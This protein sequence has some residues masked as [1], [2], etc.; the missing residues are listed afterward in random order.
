MVL[1]RLRCD[2]YTILWSARDGLGKNLESTES[3]RV[4]WHS[5]RGM[6]ELDLILVPFVETCYESLAESDQ[7]SYRALLDCEDTEL[8]AWLMQRKEPQ[9]EDLK[10]IVQR[11]VQHHA[12]AAG[13]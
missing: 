7:A 13:T 1:G 8:Y 10:A 9:S 5:R 3:S 11:I 4:Y 12:S 2:Q 6:L